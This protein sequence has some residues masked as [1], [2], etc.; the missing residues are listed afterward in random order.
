MGPRFPHHC[1]GQR[2]P[3]LGEHGPCAQEPSLPSVRCKFRAVS[4]LLKS[5]FIA[6]GNYLGESHGCFRD[7]G[8]MGFPA[9]NKILTSA[10]TSNDL[11]HVPGLGSGSTGCKRKVA[12]TSRSKKRKTRVAGGLG[13]FAT[14]DHVLCHRRTSTPP[15]TQDAAP[16]DCSLSVTGSTQH[17]NPP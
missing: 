2:P 15:A 4:L 7:I 8:K 11:P 13:G 17:T 10:N 9:Q 3:R 12:T 5:V 6:L 16:P 1:Q 14:H